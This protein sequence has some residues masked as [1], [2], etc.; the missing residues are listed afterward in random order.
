[1]SHLVTIETQV[2]H[3]EAVRLACERLQLPQPAFGKARVFSTE[4]T[5]WQIQLPGWRYPLVCDL[6]SGKLHYDTFEGRWGDQ[7]QL[8]RFLQ[9]YA[10]ERAR[11]EARRQGH[12]VTEQTLEDGSIK[13][14]VTL[15]GEA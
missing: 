8:Q 15:G 5:G 9:A 1:M 3:A 10:V 12:T 4:C 14:T 7:Q 6:E 2:T 11:L 13:L